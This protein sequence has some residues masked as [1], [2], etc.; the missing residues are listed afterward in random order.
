MR[1][2]VFSH[3]PCWTSS[4][5]PTGYATDGGFAYQMRAISELF[6]AMTIVVPCASVSASARKHEG[7]IPLHGHRVTVLPATVQRSSGL[8][9]KLL[10]P[11]WMARNFG[12]IIGA[13]RNAD[14]VHTPIPGDV[15]TIGML[16]ALVFRKPLFVRHCGNWLQPRTTAEHFWRWCIE[17]YAGG[18]NVMLATGGT[19]QPPSERN[20]NVRWIFST[21]MT[22]TELADGTVRTIP[23]AGAPI[24]LI[25]VCRQELKKGTAE[26]IASL[27]AL[28]ELLPTI[29]LDVV[30]DGSQLDALRA[31]AN[32]LGV[33]N[34]VVFHGKQDHDAVLALLRSAHLFTYPTTA[35]EGFPKVVLEALACGLPV[36]TTRVSVLPQLIGEGGGMLLD[37]ATSDAVVAAVVAALTCRSD[38]EAM[39]AEA[40][41]TA[42]QFSLEHWRDTIG[43]MLHAAWQRPL[44][45]NV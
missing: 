39:S 1:V 22:A 44:R 16:M 24:R 4:A 20:A 9:R 25:I 40:I 6:D 21:S 14:A 34:R 45:N 36:I 17:R 18:R 19:G 41:K 43:T 5:S 29:A 27:P 42:R 33:A 23:A 32:A 37:A 13:F 12:T 7:E 38:Y 10:F 11:L 30:G 26:V 8:R 35:S 28:A 3:K 2:V 31:Q 15:G